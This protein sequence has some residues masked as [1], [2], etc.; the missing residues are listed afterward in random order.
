MKK[1]RLF[2]GLAVGFG[3]WFA[4]DPR[5]RSKLCE[6]VLRLAEKGLILARRS[7]DDFSERLLLA[8]QLGLE[9]ARRKELR[10]KQKIELSG[11]N[12]ER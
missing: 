8:V 7:I 6:N 2:F 4:L 1:S 9:E 3:I 11:T 10:L 12:Q 5:L